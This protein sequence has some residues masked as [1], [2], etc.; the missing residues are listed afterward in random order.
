MHVF[1]LV[2]VSLVPFV[3][4]GSRLPQFAEKKFISGPWR[5]ITAHLAA[6]AAAATTIEESLPA[7]T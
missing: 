5:E 4:C 3:L 6:A 1:L 2:L 7:P